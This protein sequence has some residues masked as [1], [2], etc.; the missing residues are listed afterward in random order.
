M[1]WYPPTSAYCKTYTWIYKTH[2][3][4]SHET[5]I[6]V[7]IGIMKPVDTSEPFPNGWIHVLIRKPYLRQHVL[8][9]VSFIK[10]IPCKKK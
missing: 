2:F 7:V 9:L 1:A 3:M 10:E 8:V 6:A 5:F 4:P